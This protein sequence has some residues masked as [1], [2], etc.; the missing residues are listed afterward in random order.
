MVPLVCCLQALNFFSFD[1]YSRLL[2]GMMAEGNNSARFI[3]GGMAG[4]EMD[5]VE[6]NP[7]ASCFYYSDAVIQQCIV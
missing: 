6:L 1:M 3:A 7:S 5:M 4:A 2:G